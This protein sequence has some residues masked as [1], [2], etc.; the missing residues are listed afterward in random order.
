NMVTSD[1]N[2]MFAHDHRAICHLNARRFLYV[3][4]DIPYI[5][6]L[7]N[8]AR[9]ARFN[10]CVS[11]DSA[12]AIVGDLY[13]AICT[14]SRGKSVKHSAPFDLTANVSETTILYFSSLIA[15]IQ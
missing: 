2:T 3:H 7:R 9:A 8:A 1:D 5:A 15:G 14:S 6:S 13:A 12:F 4:L 11:R 10:A